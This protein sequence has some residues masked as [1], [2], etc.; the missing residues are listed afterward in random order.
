MQSGERQI[1]CDAASRQKGESRKQKAEGTGQR[2]G[3]ARAECA[4]KI[5]LFSVLFSSLRPERVYFLC[6]FVAVLFNKGG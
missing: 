4:M 2:A 6:D 3:S 5:A 1:G